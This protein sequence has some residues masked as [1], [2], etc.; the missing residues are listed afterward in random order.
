MPAP[1]PTSLIDVVDDQDRPVGTIE[2]GRALEEGKA[3]RVAHLWVFWEDRLLLQQLGRGRKRHPLQ[4]GSS[5]AAYLHSGESYEEAAGRRLREELGLELPLKR[6]AVTQMQDGQSAKFIA[7]YFAWL[8]RPDLA[9]IREPQ[10]IEALRF[11]TGPEIDRTLET[12]PE[13]FTETFRHLYA[14]YA[15]HGPAGRALH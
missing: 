7:L 9:E 3:F 11:W 6:Y 14:L 8:P 2:R 15:E 13:T 4:W 5:V 12:T 1:A 10:H